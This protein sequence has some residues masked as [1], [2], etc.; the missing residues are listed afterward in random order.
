MARQSSPH[1]PGHARRSVPLFIHV[2]HP[3]ADTVIVTPAGE[4]DMSTSPRL[5]HALAD[6]MGSGRPHLVVNLDWL[7]FMDASA[8]GVLAVAGHHFSEA[9]GTLEIECSSHLRQRLLSIGGL[10]GALTSKARGPAPEPEVLT[11]GRELRR[12]VGGA[13]DDR[14]RRD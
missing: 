14:S 10:D 7:T 5:R 9:G 11:H 1:S 2:S 13:R 6:A 4:A 12:L 3:D 8:L